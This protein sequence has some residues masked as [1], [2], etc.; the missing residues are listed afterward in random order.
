[1]RWRGSAP[2]SIG[3]LAALAL[4]IAAPS[5]ARAQTNAAGIAI[6]ADGV[7]RMKTFTDPGGQVMR[8]RIASARAT[9]DPRVT[10]FSKLR[11]VSL[12]RLEQV[13]IAHQGTLT[14]EMRYLAGLQRVRY[15]FYYPDTKDIVL[16]GPAE[17]WAPDITGRVVG[18]S[19]GR[20]VV[21]LQDVVVALRHVSGR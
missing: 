4:A 2:W 21:Q 1:M 13:I 7:L 3:L 14:D 8:E 11:K 9:L 17:G 12:N 10:T 5:A 6:D 19:S 16:A 15:V 18:L 20:P